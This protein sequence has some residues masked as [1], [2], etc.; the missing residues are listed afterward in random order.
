MNHS[1]DDETGDGCSS[2]SIQQQRAKIPEKMPLDTGTKK[3]LAIATFVYMYNHVYV[4][5]PPPPPPPPI[6][7]HTAGNTCIY[8]S[9]ITAKIGQAGNWSRD[10]RPVEPVCGTGIP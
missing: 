1:P 7:V 2:K 10:L 8:L 5:G 6:P 9:A 3:F 4:K